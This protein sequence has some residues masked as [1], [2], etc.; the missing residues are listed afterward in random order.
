M[1]LLSVSTEMLSS[2]RT[3]TLS[4]LVTAQS[5]AWASEITKILNELISELVLPPRSNPH[6]SH[7]FKRGGI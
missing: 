7:C 1:Y 2:M 3:E 6:H 4:S 5:S